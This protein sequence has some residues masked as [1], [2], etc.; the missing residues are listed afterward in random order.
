MHAAFQ[1]LHEHP[2]VVEP[3]LLRSNFLVVVQV[4]NEDALLD[5]IT[6]ASQRGLLRSAVREPDLD[7]QVTAAAFEPGAKARRLCAQLPLALKPTPCMP[8]KNWWQRI[9]K[10]A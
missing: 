9:M 10:V 7:N 2:S 6:E 5:L 8:K 3:W 1:F 4:P